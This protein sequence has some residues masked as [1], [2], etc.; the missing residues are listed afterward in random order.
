MIPGTWNVVA[1]TALFAMT[2]VTTAVTTAA[3]TAVTTAATTAATTAVM[4]L[5]RGFAV[6]AT[7][8]SPTTALLGSS[9]LW[10]AAR[11]SRHSWGL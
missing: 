11:H 9:L 10:L 4:G 3:T 7:G 2:A 1:V 6:S 5:P 8:S